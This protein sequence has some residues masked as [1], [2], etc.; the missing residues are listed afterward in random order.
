[1][2]HILLLNY[3]QVSIQAL[4]CHINC[5]IVGQII[6]FLRLKM[7][8]SQGYLKQCMFDKTKTS[9]SIAFLSPK[10][11]MWW[12]N[13]KTSG[14]R[15]FPNRRLEN[16]D[17]RTCVRMVN[18][19]NYTETCDAM[20]EYSTSIMWMYHLTTPYDQRRSLANENMLADVI[21]LHQYL[22]ACLKI[23]VVVLWSQVLSAMWWIK[24][25]NRDYGFWF[26]AVPACA[27]NDSLNTI[28]C[29]VS[30]INPPKSEHSE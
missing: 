19:N 2:M 23:C 27:Q 20:T 13:E 29:V 14:R 21:K 26:N 28:C 15:L 1:M 25:P 10:R 8:L 17:V 12:K 4:N 6:G 30:L 7:I 24:E 18:H 9:F 5:L 3:R 16:I 22:Y 11:I